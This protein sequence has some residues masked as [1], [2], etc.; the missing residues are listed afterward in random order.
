MLLR[1]KIVL[2]ISFLAAAFIYIVGNVSA[3]RVIIKNGYP[4]TV[5]AVPKGKSTDTAKL[6][7]P[8]KPIV[9]GKKGATSIAPQLM[10]SEFGCYLSG[11]TFAQIGTSET[12]Y[13]YCDTYQFVSDWAITGGYVTD[14][15][16]GYVTVYWTGSS[17]SFGAIYALGDAYGTS[18]AEL[19][20]TLSSPTPPLSG[21]SISGFSSSVCYGQTPSTITASAASGGSCGGSYSYQWQYS[22]DNATWNNLSG[23]YSQNCDPGVLYQGTYFRRSASCNGS[24]AYTDVAFISVTNVPG[25]PSI[26]NN[27]AALLCNGSSAQLAS[28]NSNTYWYQNG[29]YIGS[30]A[31]IQVTT[32]GSYYGVAYNGCGTSS[33]SNSISIST[34][35]TP[36]APVVSASGDVN[37]CSGQTV[38]LNGSASADIGW[39][40]G[41]YG[42]SIVVDRPGTYY[43]FAYNS[44]GTSGNSNV[45]T[46]SRISAP[47]V[48]AIGGADA[49]CTAT[50]TNYYNGT[51]GGVWSS[52]NT[53]VGTISGSGVFTAGTGPGTTAVNYT[54]SNTC[55]T[56]TATKY[57]TV[58]RTPS[59]TIIGESNVICGATS[60]LSVYDNN[61]GS[62]NDYDQ[63]LWYKDESYLTNVSSPSVGQGSYT[64]TVTKN[65]CSASSGAKSVTQAPPVKPT[66]SATAG[67]VICNGAA[68]TISVTNTGSFVSY[69]WYK[70]FSGTPIPGETGSTITVSSGGYYTCRAVMSTGC[71]EVSDAV[72]MNAVSFIPSVSASSATTFC[73]GNA[74]TLNAS[75]GTSYQWRN[76]GTD[77]GGQTGSSIY[78]TSSGNYT[79]FAT[80]N[81]G[82]SAV[83][84]SL[85]V[86]V[87]PVPAA[88]YISVSGSTAFCE[89]GA[90]MLTAPSSYGYEW[91]KNDAILSGQTQQYLYV[92]QAGT[93]R[94]AVTNGY[95]CKSA[96]GAPVAVTVYALPSLSAISGAS[97][98]CVNS[99]IGLSNSTPGGSWSSNNTGVA[100]VN[101]SG[102]V[103]GVG[104]GT[105]VITYSYTNGN[106][107]SSSV[108]TTITVYALPSLAAISGAT[109]VCVNNAI[110]L[111]NSTPGGSWS[112]NNTG[113]ASI[114][115]SG[116]VTGVGAGTAVITYSYTNGNGCSSSVSTTITV[117]A[118]PSLAAI[119]GASSVCVNSTIGLSNSTAGGSWSSNNTGVA[120]INASGTV[121][122]VGAGTAV[123]TYSYTNGNGCSSSVSTTITV[124][125][126]PSLAA[127]SGT[128][129]VCVNSAIGLSNST[130]GGSWSSNNTGVA[131]V[132]GSGTVTGISAGTAVI[133]YSYTNGN[134]CS[135]SV[136]TTITVYALPSLAVI[137]GAS[138]V[139]VNN[140]IALNNS[141]PGGSWSSNNTGVASIDASGTVTGISA[142]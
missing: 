99:V 3:Q 132:N 1:K 57:V 23:A 127:I 16:A 123:I 58:N 97:S 35:N 39:S 111:N 21:G 24:V 10:M 67:V 12:Y 14:V 54:V 33:A 7:A 48:E 113:V 37:I 11:Q 75:G 41:D 122:G 136:S 120:S 138:S 96:P 22:Y 28:N 5:Y 107:C 17:G 78:I 90:V 65:G 20:V 131:T 73:D 118:L 79:V 30:G 81:N 76:G 47:A 91:I 109:S 9:S 141:T 18:I 27:G 19:Y 15:G 4:A 101:G 128:S 74:V 36:A 59:P 85:Q 38:T 134:G 25:A 88:P 106:G 86:T 140:A 56:T 108:S 139:C 98:V 44:C 13:L 124:Y 29:T 135:S 69:T 105:A 117:Y 115:A 40:T 31:N 66:I 45:V 93:Y 71:S 116:T 94:V 77:I 60:S 80:D 6:K 133:T 70:D 125:A 100:T 2:K 8:P 89:N 103:T 62:V 102:T 126:L 121:T 104:A 34:M 87:Y 55:G 84:A 112:S 92:Q 72:Y 82:C 129:S 64:V 63:F 46:V 51:S 83:S 50:T 61:T 119:S 130:P 53:S 43:A 26:Q 95:G 114:N 137:S 142:G 42:T 68:K 49:V 110:A 52:S 32:A